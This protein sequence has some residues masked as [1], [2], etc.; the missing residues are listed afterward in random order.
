MSKMN[1]RFKYMYDAAPESALLPKDHA[2]HVASFNGPTVALPTLGGYWNVP[3]ISAELAFAVAINVEAVDH[4]TGDETYALA[5]TF[6][7]DGTFA[8]KVAAGTVSVKGT[9]QYVILVDIDTVVAQLGA[10]PTA[11]RI[12]AALAGTTPSITAHAWLA[13]EIKDAH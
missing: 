1:S 6:G 10:A 9:G 2:A 5:L 8:T 3:A 11:V 4:T 7:V 12:E 13:G